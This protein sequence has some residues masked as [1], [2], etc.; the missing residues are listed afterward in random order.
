MG[1]RIQCP[2]LA[3][4]IIH[5]Y[6]IRLGIINISWRSGQNRSPFGF[7]FFRQAQKMNVHRDG[8]CSI[9]QW[10]ET[11]GAFIGVVLWNVK[12]TIVEEKCTGVVL[13]CKNKF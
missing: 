6:L 1:N 4:D 10:I 11:S 5:L 13:E 12:T 2:I 3:K 9:G 7:G 8:I